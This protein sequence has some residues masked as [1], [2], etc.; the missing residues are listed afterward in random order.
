MKPE[1]LTPRV[2]V[3]IPV[4]QAE[5]VL[6]DCLTTVLGQTFP[7]EQYEV[8]VVNN[9]STDRTVAIA[10]GFP[11][12]VVDEPAPGVARA[13][14]R[15]LAEARGELAAFIDA[16]CVA[17]PTWLEALVRRYDSG[18]VG[19][20]PPDPAMRAEQLPNVKNRRPAVCRPVAQQP[21]AHLPERCN[22]LAG[23]GGYLPGYNAR[24]P[25]QY[26][27]AEKRMLSQEMAL[28]D[29]RNSAPFIVT[30]NALFVRRLALEVGGFDDAMTNGEDADLC[31]RL[32][33][34]GWRFAFAPDA[35]AYHKHRV[36]VRALCRWMYIYGKESV[37]LMK[38]HRRR[39]GIRFV[40]IDP[41]HYG[42]WL[43]A[44]ARFLQ[45]WPVEGMEWER[46]FFGY[47]VLRYACYTAGRV[48]GSIKYRAIIL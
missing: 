12:R 46:R 40:M 4:Y 3:I 23:V 29:L 16:D 33:D 35:V 15:G 11:V 2:S 14:N 36:S 27:I 9:G 38:K 17:E 25:V 24:T 37:Y 7:R 22:P 34:R 13:R 47:D 6:A 45:P 31:W 21:A 5:G 41:V 44:L 10:A 19:D 20:V 30:A 1:T 26:Y 18:E 42:R 28:L 32:A 43:Y 48:V 39:Y 8:I